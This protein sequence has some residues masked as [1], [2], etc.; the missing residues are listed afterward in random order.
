MLQATCYGTQCLFQILLFWLQVTNITDLSSAYPFLINPNGGNVGIGT[1]SPNGPLDIIGA[2]YD[3]K[4]TISLY[5]SAAVAADIGGGIYFGGNY[6]GT[7]KTGWAGILGRKDNATSGEYGGYMAFYTRT[8]GTAPAERMR[9]SSAGNLLIGT[10]SDYGTGNTLQ[11]S[12]GNIRHY[13]NNE[14]CAITHN[15][16]MTVAN[17]GTKTV[18]VTNG[19]L[20]FISENNTGDGALFYAGYKSATVVVIADPNGRYAG[21]NTAGKACLYKSANNGT[22]TFINNLGSS[23]SFTIYAITNSD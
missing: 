15:G 7:T 17:G 4:Y 14:T 11:V 2:T 22:A 6:T 12:G 8:N 3:G 13:L 1:S 16:S 9:I 21:T 19:G 23:L 20:I 5:D 18:T 10:Q